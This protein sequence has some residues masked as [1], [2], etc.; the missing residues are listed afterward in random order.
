MRLIIC[1]FYF[2]PPKFEFT[3]EWSCWRARIFL[4]VLTGC[5]VFI[6]TCKKLEV[7]F[8]FDTVLCIM[9]RNEFWHIFHFTCVRFQLSTAVKLETKYFRSSN[10]SPYPSTILSIVMW[11]SAI[12]LSYCGPGSAVISYREVPAGSHP[13]RS[14]LWEPLFPLTWPCWPEPFAAT[15][16]GIADRAWLVLPLLCAINNSS[17]KY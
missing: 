6:C 4:N 14:Q 8:H 7:K 10:A 11:F 1:L 2:F 9:G 17:V 5:H 16:L 15:L 3:F 12:H 13:Y